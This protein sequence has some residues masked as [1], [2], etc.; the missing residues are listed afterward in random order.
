MIPGHDWSPGSESRRQGQGRMRKSS[1]NEVLEEEEEL[2]EGREE[3]ALWE[4]VWQTS[5]GNLCFLFNHHG[6]FSIPSNNQIL[7]GASVPARPHSSFSGLSVV[8]CRVA[9]ISH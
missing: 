4:E 5:F 7:H 2:E 3:R 9:S 6:L 8:V 1:R